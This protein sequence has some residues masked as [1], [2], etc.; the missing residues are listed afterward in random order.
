[1]VKV[2]I[3]LW[4]LGV[5]E[6]V[7]RNWQNDVNKKSSAE[8]TIKDIAFKFWKLFFVSCLMTV[9]DIKCVW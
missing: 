9:P 5:D 7:S 3:Y 2:W 6:I 1:M 4:L 8:Q